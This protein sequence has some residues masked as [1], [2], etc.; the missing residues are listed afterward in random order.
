MT[1]T[2]EEQPN[3]TKLEGFD[4]YKSI[5]C[6]KYVVAP[7]VDQSELPFRMLCKRYGAQLMYTPMFHSKI[8]CQDETY[9]QVQFTTCAEDTPICVQ[10]CANNPEIFV[11][12]A[13]LL[14]QMYPEHNKNI[15]TIDLNL[16]CPQGIAKR[17]HYGSYLMEEPKLIC[18]MVKAMHAQIDK[19]ISCKI[20]VF[21]DV[22]HTVH[23]AE[24]ILD[25][26]CQLLTVHGR[27][28]ET[29]KND[30][31]NIVYNNCN[32][33]ISWD[34]QIGITSRQFEK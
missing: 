22:Q 24:Q 12:A 8:W 31:K 32:I 7:M 5:G 14:L 20:R 18:D 1:T 4:L 21:K 25:A 16:G 2:T 23:Y 13:K 33:F 11:E 27:T 3:F 10:F 29:R 15:A 6:P 9:R 34:Q 19:P 30:V 28:R 26:G 17:G